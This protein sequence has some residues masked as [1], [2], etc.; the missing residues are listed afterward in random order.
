[1]GPFALQLPR[2]V[3]PM[4]KMIIVGL[5]SATALT[6]AAG[7]VL[8]FFRWKKCNK[9]STHITIR[10]YNA[11]SPV[12]YGT[13]VA[14][15]CCPLLTSGGCFAGAGFAGPV[16][17]GGW[18]AGFHDG[19]WVS[20]DVQIHDGHQGNPAP[21]G[22]GGGPNFT[23]PQPKP[24]NPSSQA[25]PGM[26]PYGYPPVAPAGYQPYYTGYQPGA[27]P[28]YYPGYPQMPAWPQQQMPPWM[29]QQGYGMPNYWQGMMGR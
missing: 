26:A 11:F 12:C 15:G 25:W 28:G 1:M 22:G 7:E 27:M 21:S 9:F 29:M 10:Q 4:K 6:L 8:A 14:D 17:G 18:D 24:V 23:P 2:T 3:T 20:G 19:G 16:H 13:I 5:L